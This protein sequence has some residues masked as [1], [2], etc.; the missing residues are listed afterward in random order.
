ME[1]LSKLGSGG[2]SR[3]SLGGVSRLEFVVVQSGLDGVGDGGVG[4]VV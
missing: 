1:N 4:M 3:F 2:E